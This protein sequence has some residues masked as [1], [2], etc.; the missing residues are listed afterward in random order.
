MKPDVFNDLA[1][2]LEVVRDAYGR[3]AHEAA[4]KTDIYTVWR[5]VTR[6]QEADRRAR[7]ARDGQWVS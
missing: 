6:M 1:D 5:A 3:I 4:A 7:K 2:A